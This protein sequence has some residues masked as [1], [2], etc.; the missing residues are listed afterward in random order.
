MDDTPLHESDEVSISER[1]DAR[2]G[3]EIRLVKNARTV[4]K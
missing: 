1:P 2:Y 3:P 4:A